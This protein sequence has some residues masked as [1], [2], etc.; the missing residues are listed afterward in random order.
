M[1]GRGSSSGG[2]SSGTSIS[3]PEGKRRRRSGDRRKKI[4]TEPGNPTGD[5]LPLRP[6]GGGQG[7]E[8][9]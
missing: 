3:V 7:T 6:A 5:G 9:Q 4:K 1:G 2:S 8:G